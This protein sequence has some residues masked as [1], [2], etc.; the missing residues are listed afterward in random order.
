MP[1]VQASDITKRFNGTTALAGVDLTVERGESLALLGPS[2]CGKTTLLRVLAGLEVPDQGSVIVSGSTLAD[3]TTF[4]PPERRRIGM[5]FQDWALFPHLTVARNVAFG[6]DKAEIGRGRISE[7]LE[8]V[9]LLHL[10]D[11]YPDEL[12]GG[13][14][15]RV[16]LARALAP[17]P[18]VLLFDEPFSNLD[19]GLRTQVRADVA[20]LM[21]EVGMT[22]VF[23]TH[24]QEESF[25]VG[26]RVAVMHEGRI[27]QVGRPAE[28]YQYPV[29]P[30][31]ATFL[32]EANV[33]NGV[34]NHRHVSTIV[35]HVP[36]ADPVYGPC[37]VVI[38]PEHLTVGLGDKAVVSSVEF[39]GHDTSYE[40][41]VN[42]TTM[43]A[44]V[45]AAP[46]FTPGDRVEVT[47]AG[48]NT[49][50]FQTA[51]HQGP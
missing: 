13:Q 48:P 5:V 23:V 2:G 29:S 49:V 42:G 6:L 20:E 12:S 46:R 38:R 3:S 24:D 19:T 45:I 16:A 11:R 30:W 26:D 18:R 1:F 7:T 37:Q 47:Y 22:S 50:A 9:G 27:V 8:L 17:R 4:V 31:V 10:A 32:G 14:A 33:L 51:A 40:L 25:V 35:G 15:Q 39:Y 44:R 43:L 41:A 28:V 36:L 34:A 21:R